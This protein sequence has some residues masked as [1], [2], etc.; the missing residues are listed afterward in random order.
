MA[1]CGRNFVAVLEAWKQVIWK[2]NGR[3]PTSDFY[4]KVFRQLKVAM[5]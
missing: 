5:D 3:A 2:L 1:E 4:F